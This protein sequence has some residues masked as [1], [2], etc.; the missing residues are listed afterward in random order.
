[1]LFL[2]QNVV[3]LLMRNLRT[4]IVIFTFLHLI[5]AHAD[6]DDIDR[7]LKIKIAYLYHFSQFTQWAKPLSTLNYCVFNDVAISELIKTTFIGKNS[8]GTFKLMVHAIT[9][10]DDVDDCQIIFFPHAVSREILNTTY[11]KP[12]LT[13]GVQKDF[14]QQGGIVYLFEEDQKI[15]FFINNID[16]QESNLKI[17]S[18]LLALSRLPP[19]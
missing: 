11:H 1:M 8:N 15:R 2:H 18:Q 7:E 16:A 3:Q 6:S 4:A 14:T 17:N 9:E 5:P 12:I 19:P 13:V 10:H